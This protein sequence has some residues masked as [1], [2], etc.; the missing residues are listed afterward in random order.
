MSAQTRKEALALLDRGDSI[1][2][3]FSE[4]ALPGDGLAGIRLARHAARGRPGIKV[5]YAGERELAERLKLLLFDCSAVL[6][7]PYTV[8]Q[9]RK[10]A[11]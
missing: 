2:V 10:L 9:L 3:L 11:A 1:D 6:E 8:D 7:K 4:I 5:L